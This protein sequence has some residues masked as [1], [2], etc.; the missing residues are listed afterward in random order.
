MNDTN[1]IAKEFVDELLATSVRTFSAQTGVTDT[2]YIV[3]L[4]KLALEDSMPEIRR[5]VYDA[6]EMPWLNEK[7]AR[8]LVQSIVNKMITLHMLR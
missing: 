5:A 1:R 4:A 7:I 6:I 8:D 2:W 3:A